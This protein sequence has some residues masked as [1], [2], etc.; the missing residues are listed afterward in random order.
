[1]FFPASRK[2]A[3]IRKWSD[4][5][6]IP[7]LITLL[8]DPSSLVRAAAADGDRHRQLRLPVRLIR[9]SPLWA[10]QQ[11]RRHLVA[12]AFGQ[13]YVGRSYCAWGVV[14]VAWTYDQSA[15]KLYC[16][17]QPVATNVIG[18]KAI[19]A[20]TAICALAGMTTTTFIFTV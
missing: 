5:T 1:M 20:A 6:A 11:P 15:M 19:S 18:P 14:H 8:G 16:N 2:L 13:G 3:Q 9:E 12:V 10:V 17:G 4:E 7:Q